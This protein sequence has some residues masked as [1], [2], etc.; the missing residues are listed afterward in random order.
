MADLLWAALGSRHRILEHD[1][2]TWPVG[3]FGKLTKFGKAGHFASIATDR[4]AHA[5]TELLGPSWHPE[6]R[7]G[8]PLITFPVPLPWDVPDSW[9]IDF[10]PASPLAAVRMFAF[11]TSVRPRG[12]GTTIVAGSHRL[13]ERRIGMRSSDL[14]RD[15]AAA[16]PWFRDLWRPIDEDR[17][18]RFMVEGAEVEGVHVRVVELTGEPGDVVLWHPSL[19]HAIAADALDVPRFMLTHTARRGDAP[20]PR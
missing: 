2:A 18:Q 20:A 9:H 6:G 8:Q 16:S 19:L 10:A 11:L 5:V 4:I 15:L 12:G 14:R 7:W 17:V 13:A 1:P 3:F